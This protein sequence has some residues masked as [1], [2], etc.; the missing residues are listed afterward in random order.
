MNGKH[1][2][3]LQ[4]PTEEKRLSLDEAMTRLKAAKIVQYE[5]GGARVYFEDAHGNRDLI[6]DIYG[7]G[8]YRDLLLGLIA[9]GSR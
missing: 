4:A 1:S 5:H 9:G 3:A 6:M 2:D 7:E 8:H